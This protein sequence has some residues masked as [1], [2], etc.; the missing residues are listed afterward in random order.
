MDENTEAQRNYVMAQHATNIGTQILKQATTFPLFR[1]LSLNQK[2]STVATLF[3]VSVDSVK[4]QLQTGHC[5]TASFGKK[6]EEA[7]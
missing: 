3:S 6:N 5:P 2:A 1:A 4:S 7:Q